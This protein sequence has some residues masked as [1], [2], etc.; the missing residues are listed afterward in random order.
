MKHCK[1]WDYNRTLT[2]SEQDFTTI[3][4][5]LS[6]PSNQTHRKLATKAIWLQWNFDGFL[7]LRTSNIQ[8]IR[9]PAW[10]YNIFLIY[11]Y[12][13]I[14]IYYIILYLRWTWIYWV[15]SKDPASL[16]RVSIRLPQPQHLPFTSS[17]RF[18][19]SRHFHW[20]EREKHKKNRTPQ[21]AK[22]SKKTNKDQKKQSRDQKKNKKGSKKNK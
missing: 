10:I 14:S 5:M 21:F 4:S 13:Y 7:K 15:L 9:F 20:I 22:G 6:T 18:P 11:V 16:L 17:D 19:A 12:I 2:I 8:L 3:H 1:S